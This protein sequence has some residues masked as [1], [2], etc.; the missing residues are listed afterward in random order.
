MQSLSFGFFGAVATRLAILMCNWRAV[1]MAGL[2][3]RRAIVVVRIIVVVMSLI[4]LTRVVSTAVAMRR[5][6]LVHALRAGTVMLCAGVI[7]T[8]SHGWFS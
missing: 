4:I 1:G 2:V 8:S 7:I 6:V 3:L 5:S